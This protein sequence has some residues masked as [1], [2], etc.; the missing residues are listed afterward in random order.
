MEITGFVFVCIVFS[1][2]LGVA[3]YCC[4]RVCSTEIP[5][6]ENV[7]SR[8]NSSVSSISI[9][10]TLRSRSSVVRSNSPKMSL[11]AT[12]GINTQSRSKI[13][14]IRPPQPPAPRIKVDD[15]QATAYSM[16]TSLYPPKPLPIEHQR[17]LD[18]LTI[19]R[20]TH[21]S[22]A[23]SRSPCPPSSRTSEIKPETPTPKSEE[24]HEEDIYLSSSISIQNAVL[25]PAH[26][27]SLSSSSPMYRRKMLRQTSEPPLPPPP[28]YAEAIANRRSLVEPPLPREYLI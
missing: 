18:K 24:K 20:E 7:G 13:R 21:R 12:N 26:P 9:S 19:E 25:E 11:P 5:Y 14:N 2:M 22:R 15:A 17:S 8:K 28:S 10:E 3:G 6:N 1:V 23:R 4:L 27:I 16:V